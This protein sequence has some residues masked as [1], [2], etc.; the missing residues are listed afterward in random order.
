LIKVLTLVSAAFLM[1]CNSTAS[2]STNVES[3]STSTVESTTSVESS[4]T[5]SET[6]VES[7]SST[8]SESSTSS[9]VSSDSSVES[10]SSSEVSVTDNELTFS[11]LN[12]SCGSQGTDSLNAKLKDEMNTAAGFEFVTTVDNTSC[13]FMADAPTTGSQILTIGSAKKAGNLEITFAET[14]KSLTITVETYS[15]SYTQGGTEH[16][17][18]DANS[19]LYFNT[20]EN[21]IDL[22]PVEGQP[23]T[24]EYSEAINAKSFKVYNKSGNARVFIKTLKVVY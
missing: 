1:A 5:T 19:V 16:T 7:T 14:I 24:K 2:T 6:S 9:T 22:K 13:Q 11:F 21:V 15:K 8:T 3:T 10:S 17:N 20:D 4:L 23:V 18:V 12:P